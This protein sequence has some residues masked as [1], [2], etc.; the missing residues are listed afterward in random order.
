MSQLCLIITPRDRYGEDAGKMT[1]D[2]FATA[3][4][5]AGTAWNIFK[6]RKAFNPA[7][8]LPSSLVKNAPRKKL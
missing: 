3:R 5:T 1:E 6:L 8:N 4:H 7:S 2:A